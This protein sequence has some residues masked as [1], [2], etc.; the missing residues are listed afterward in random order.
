MEMG[1]PLTVFSKA[2]ADTLTPHHS[3]DL[4]INLEEGAT[5]LIGPIY[6]LL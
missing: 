3:Y 1:H 2:K 6:S 4:K 5:P